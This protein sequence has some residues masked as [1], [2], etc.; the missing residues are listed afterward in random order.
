MINA[1]K[2]FLKERYFIIGFWT[3]ITSFVYGK[4]L[5]IARNAIGFRANK[6][7]ICNVCGGFNDMLCNIE[8]HCRHSLIAG[9]HLIIDTIRYSGFLDDLNNYFILPP[10]IISKQLEF[11]A[12][13]NYCYI[14]RVRERERERERIGVWRYKAA[15]ALR[16]HNVMILT[17]AKTAK[18]SLLFD[19][20]ETI[21]LGWLIP[22]R[23]ILA[24]N[25]LERLT[26]RENIRTRIRSTIAKFGVYDAIHIRNSDNKTDYKKAFDDI[27][28]KVDKNLVLC[29]DSRE[30]QLYAKKLF[31]D[32]LLL[33]HELPNT[34]GETL[35][36]NPNLDRYETNV[37]AI[38]DLFILACADRLFSS[39][40]LGPQGNITT[41]ASGFQQLAK[42]LRSRRSL[43]RKM[44]R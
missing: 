13:P 17:N 27:K 1:V 2:R 33:S 37:N 16:D 29:T 43:V 41:Y 11:D 8:H 39:Y 19:A 36:G 35:H 31:G 3:A 14:E 34:N 7:I 10:Y 9:R 21:M 24:I 38:I 30:C 18:L 28:H 20:H 40:L 26:L 25:A 5:A 15:E 44:L 4:L 23:S 32:K 42:I 22:S 12:Y 6:Y